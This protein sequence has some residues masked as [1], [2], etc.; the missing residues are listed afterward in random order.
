[1]RRGWRA[2]EGDV[3]KVLTMLATESRVYRLHLENAH[4][5]I[6][7]L[8]EDFVPGGLLLTSITVALAEPA[9]LGVSRHVEQLALEA[10]RELSR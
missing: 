8:A 4:P 1:M 6:E 9:R 7:R 5:V 2:D 3:L 10:F